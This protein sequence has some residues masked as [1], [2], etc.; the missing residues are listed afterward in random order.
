MTNFEK[1][2]INMTDIETDT[3]RQDFICKH[4]KDCPVCPLDS[5]CDGSNDAELEEWLKKEAED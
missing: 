4:S 3:P 1:V 5:R 2:L